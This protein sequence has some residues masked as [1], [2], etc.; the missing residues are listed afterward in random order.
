MGTL[1]KNVVSHG[2]KYLDMCHVK[3]QGRISLSFCQ[4]AC[5]FTITDF[6]LEAPS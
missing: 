6:R 5:L 3:D 4:S 2:V 1:R